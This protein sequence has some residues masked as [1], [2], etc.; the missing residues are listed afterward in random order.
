M[1]RV[2]MKKMLLLTTLPLL[3]LPLPLLRRAA[4]IYEWLVWC[5]WM[6]WV[7]QVHDMTVAVV[8]ALGA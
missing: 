2:L 1:K 6:F 4:A 8:V 5:I 3:P 7:S